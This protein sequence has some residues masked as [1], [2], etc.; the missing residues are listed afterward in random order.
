MEDPILMHPLIAPVWNW[1]EFPHRLKAVAPALAGSGRRILDAGCGNHS[2][3][4]TKRH[5]PEV[6]YHGID[7]SEWNRDASDDAAIDQFFDLSLDDLEALAEVPDG[8]YDAVVCSH[9]LEHLHAPLDTAAALVGKLRPGGIAYFEVPS[10]RTVDWPSAKEGWMGIRGCLNFYDDPTHTDPVDLADVA[11]RLRSEGYAVEGPH[12]R[13]MKR[14]L[15]LLPAYV[16]AGLLLRG[17]VPA[18]VVWD[19]SGFADAI[20]VRA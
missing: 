14:R 15:A 20:V 3:S 5:F 18:T 19:V 13:R 16:G 8:A 10:P 7:N 11:G 12:V 9:V 2:P 1:F 17:Y 6:E 4:I